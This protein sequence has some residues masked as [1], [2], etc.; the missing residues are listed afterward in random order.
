MQADARPPPRSLVAVDVVV[1]LL[2]LQKDAAVLLD[3]RG[4]VT[5]IADETRVEVV[6][7]TSISEISGTS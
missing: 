7:F 4:L 5:N 2:R 1:V 3:L 6:V